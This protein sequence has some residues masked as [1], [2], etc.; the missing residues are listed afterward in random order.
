MPVLKLKHCIIH[1]VDMDEQDP[2]RRIVE[3]FVNEEDVFEMLDS[4]NPKNIIKYLDQRKIPHRDAL[5]INVKTIDGCLPPK[6]CKNKR[7]RAIN[8]LYE[9]ASR[10]NHKLARARELLEQYGA[11]VVLADDTQQD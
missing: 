3:L 10:A 1:D 4:I 5:Q 2:K 11:N 7:S 6:T 8:G 9:A